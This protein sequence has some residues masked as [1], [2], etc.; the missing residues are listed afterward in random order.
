MS[1]FSDFERAPIVVSMTTHK[2]R[3][4]SLGPTLHSL[5]NQ[6]IKP[7]KILVYCAPGADLFPQ[8]PL[9]EY[10]KCAEDLGPVMK[11]SAAVLADLPAFAIVITVDD[12]IIYSREL[13]ATILAGCAQF[14]N[15]ALGFSGWNV[16]KLIDE[17]I[18]E[19]PS[20]LGRIDVLEGWAGA[21]YRA[22]FFGPSILTPSN[23]F[24]FVDDVWISAYLNVAGIERRI[25]GQPMAVQAGNLSGLHDRSDFIDLN[26]HAARIGFPAKG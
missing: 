19:W 17:G 18:Y 7:D 4:G 21:A 13:I 20:G 23:V 10:V 22:G 5:T 25:I 9:V 2:A 11:I 8:H 6:T 12:D 3:N 24:K 26:R 1:E 14:P 15:A 16:R